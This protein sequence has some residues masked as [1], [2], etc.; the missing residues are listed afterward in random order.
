MTVEVAGSSLPLI[1]IVSALL[2]LLI[3]AKLFA[4]L[5]HRVKIPAVLGE[6]L[7]G[8]IV[9]PFALGGLPMIC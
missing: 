4:E 8:I 9:S 7:A 3:T 5:F 6:L 1:D 2:V